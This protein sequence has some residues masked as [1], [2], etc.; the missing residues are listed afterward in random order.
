MRSLETGSWNEGT[1]QIPVVMMTVLCH[2]S[3][4]LHQ[5]NL[6]RTCQE[7]CQE[8]LVG[9]IQEKQY[10]WDRGKNKYPVR[11]CRVCSAHK[12]QNE[13][14]ICEFCVVPL[15]RGRCFEKYNTF[16]HQALFVL[17]TPSDIMV[18]QSQ[19]RSVHRDIPCF[20]TLNDQKC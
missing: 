13:T 15:H 5:G 2:Y 7:D 9:T 16:K 8:I 14:Y 18:H 4:D 17:Q 1:W 10:V 3:R 19:D 12:K 6:Q 20:K 11:Q